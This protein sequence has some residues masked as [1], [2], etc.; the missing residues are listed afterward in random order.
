MPIESFPTEGKSKMLVDFFVQ[1]ERG[2][3]QSSPVFM[4][5][6]SPTPVSCVEF[7]QLTFFILKYY[8]LK[9]FKGRK[10]FNHYFTIK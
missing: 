5:C 7:K 10:T 9:Y 1:S 6:D 2:V 8:D 4:A 3:D